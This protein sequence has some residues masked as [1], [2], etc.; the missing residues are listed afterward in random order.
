MAIAVGSV[1]PPTYVSVKPAGSVAAAAH[2]LIKTAPAAANSHLLIV[3]P[4]YAS[5]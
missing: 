5:A 4:V 1:R 3:R 2:E